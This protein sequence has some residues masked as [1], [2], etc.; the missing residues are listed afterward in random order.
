MR[1]PAGLGNILTIMLEEEERIKMVSSL[2]LPWWS[3]AEESTLL[4]QGVWI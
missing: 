4:M 2:G 1:G 3:S